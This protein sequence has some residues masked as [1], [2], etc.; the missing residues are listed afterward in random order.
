[1]AAQWNKLP[2][3][4]FLQQHYTENKQTNTKDKKTTKKKCTQ[5]QNKIT[6]MKKYIYFKTVIQIM[7]IK[8]TLQTSYFSEVHINLA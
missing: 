4:A 7:H 3:I 8:V 1:L 2:N 6:K 5:L